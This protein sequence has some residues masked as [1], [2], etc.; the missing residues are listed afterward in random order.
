MLILGA[1]QMAELAARHLLSAKV[2]R[3]Y[4]A[5][6]TIERGRELAAKFQAE[7]VP[8]EDF[9][10]L[11]RRVDVVLSSTGATQPIL[12][13]AMAEEAL[14]ARLG[15]SLFIIDI[16]MP[17][18]VEDAAGDLDHVYLYTLKD[19]QGIVDENMGERRKE[20]A[21]AQALVDRVTGEFAS[22]LADTVAGKQAS[23]RHAPGRSAR[24]GERPSSSPPGAQ[25]AQPR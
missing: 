23:L 2:S 25:E 6:R 21:A 15:R 5:N 13:R 11:L 1:G 16:A 7:S 18:D 3:L 20:I 4:I 12:T 8:W 17:R 22:W 14:E 10:A 9:P 24:R 19:L